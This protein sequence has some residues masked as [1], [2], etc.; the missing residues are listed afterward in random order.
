M[1]AYFSTAGG[2]GSPFTAFSKAVPTRCQLPD[3]R[4]RGHDQRRAEPG[5]VVER[6]QVAGKFIEDGR[7]VFLSR[8]LR[9]GGGDARRNQILVIGQ[10][11]FPILR[12]L[13]LKRVLELLVEQQPLEDLADGVLV[14]GA[15][16]GLDFLDPVVF[17]VKRVERRR[18]LV[19]GDNARR[20]AAARGF[21][22]ATSRT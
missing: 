21:F 13:R 19:P 17:P 2:M 10:F 7:V 20:P 14:G 18:D 8:L 5:H 12:V 1:A 22:P 11:L 4:C 16:D 3:G 6:L 9:P 15:I